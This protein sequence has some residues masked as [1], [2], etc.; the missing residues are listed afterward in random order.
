MADNTHIQTNH[1]HDLA[2]EALDERQ[3]GKVRSSM[4][5]CRSVE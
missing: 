2:D 3:A 1:D 4:L 5:C